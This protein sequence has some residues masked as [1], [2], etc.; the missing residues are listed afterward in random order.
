MPRLRTIAEPGHQLLY[1][2]KE[3]MLLRQLVAPSLVFTVMLTACGGNPSPSDMGI[4]PGHGTAL[5]RSD[6][7]SIVY[8]L[9]GYS[10]STQELNLIERAGSIRI[11]Q[12]MS[13]NG[14]PIDLIGSF[15]DRTSAAER[16]YGIWLMLTA[17]QYGYGRPEENLGTPQ[18]E[19]KTVEFNRQWDSCL[20]EAVPSTSYGAD[21]NALS[22]QLAARATAAAK[23]D[24]RTVELVQAWKTCLQAQGATFKDNETWS[25]I[26]ARSDTETAIRVAISDVRCKEDMDFVQKM[27]DIEASYQATLISDNEAGLLAQRQKIEKT[28]DEAAQTVAAFVGD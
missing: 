24:P 17:E 4:S 23:K 2:L 7:E 11:Q 3:P 19:T 26:E 1:N 28:L 10:V 22:V 16:P 21:Q 20:G 8:P 12:C 27:A 13:K 18:L 14:Q 25:P 6:M 9:D 15:K 5:L